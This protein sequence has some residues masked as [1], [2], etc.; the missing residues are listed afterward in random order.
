M[1]RRQA[2][3]EGRGLRDV[4]VALRQMKAENEEDGAGDAGAAVDG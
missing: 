4:T 3:A 1:W 2:P